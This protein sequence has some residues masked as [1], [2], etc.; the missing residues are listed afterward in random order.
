MPRTFPALLVR[1]PARPSDEYLE[2]LQAEIDEDGPT[3]IEDR[4]DGV[5]IFFTS[6][7]DRDC[8][9]ARVAAFD[10]AATL[11]PAAIDDESW[12]ERSQASVGAID[13]GRITVA[14]PWVPDPHASSRIRIVIEPSMGFGTGHHPSTRLCL[15][16]LQTQNLSGALA[17]DIGT[18]SGVLAIAAWRLGAREVVAIDYDPDA[19][20]SAQENVD[21]NG[22]A[23]FVHLRQADIVRD[24][25][26]LPGVP[27]VILAN[28]TG[29]MLQR[30][31]PIL[32]TMAGAG[33]RLIISG[34]QADEEA[35][36][37]AAF[38]P[39][40]VPEAR[41]EEATWVSVLLRSKR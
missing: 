35:E 3:A 5:D 37:V 26:A 23:G 41:A 10:P 7:A 15:G 19:L 2:R 40:F 13:V 4:D 30:I 36:V 27:R 11:S 28:I 39:V 29:A 25:L 38:A 20:I 31:A 14:P 24:G 9:Q 22:A 1:W 16:L 18:G 17:V 33:T 32:G 12:A 21:R 6:A 8:A 34:F